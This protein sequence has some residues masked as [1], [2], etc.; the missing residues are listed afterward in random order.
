MS[1]HEDPIEAPQAD[2]AEDAYEAEPVAA[3]APEA[4]ARITRADFLPLCEAD[5]KDM[6]RLARDAT[7]TV[8]ALNS[9]SPQ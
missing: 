3:V 6:A 7:G 1:W 8:A 9:V 4:A 2:V 5:F